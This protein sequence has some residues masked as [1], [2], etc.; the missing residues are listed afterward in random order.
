M[1]WLRQHLLHISVGFLTLNILGLWI[2]VYLRMQ[3]TVGMSVSQDATTIDTQLRTNSAVFTDLTSEQTALVLQITQLQE[4]VASLSAQVAS[5]EGLQKAASPTVVTTTAASTPREQSIYIGSG[6]SNKPEWV[7]IDSAALEFNTTNY[8]GLDSATFEATLSVVG[9]EASAR[10]RNKTTGH[11]ITAAEV[12]H[13][14]G[15]ATQKL[16]GSFQLGSGNNAYVVQ[17]RSSGNETATLHSSR[18]R[19]SYR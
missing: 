12:T 3:N 18:L 14:T 19:L 4:E 16:S 17:L 5:Q 9:G 15:S 11:I 8:P 2:F 1:I 7:D 10:L 6:N 13:N